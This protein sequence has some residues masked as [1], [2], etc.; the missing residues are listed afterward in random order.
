LLVTPG[1]KGVGCMGQGGRPTTWLLATWGEAAVVLQVSDS[2][3]GVWR[4]PGSL[5]GWSGSQ[6]LLYSWGEGCGLPGEGSR[7][8]SWLLAAWG[9]AAVVL[10]ASGPTEEVWESA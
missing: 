9:K 6:D 5:W 8:T 2:I 7:P 1:E 3:E 4:Y 10:H